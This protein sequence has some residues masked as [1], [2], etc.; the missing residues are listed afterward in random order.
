MKKLFIVLVIVMMIIGLVSCAPSDET[1]ASIETGTSIEDIVQLFGKPHRTHLYSF[2]TGT[3]TTY[4]Y[5]YLGLPHKH[6][7]KI[8]FDTDLEV[9][10]VSYEY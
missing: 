7:L 8:M 5:K 10:S 3:T 6:N 9:I 4:Q 1:I 2:P